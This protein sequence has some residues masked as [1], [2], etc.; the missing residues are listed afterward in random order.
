MTSQQWIEKSDNYIMRT[1]GRY[2]IVPVRGEGCRLW[3]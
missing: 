3:E 2:P 1:Y